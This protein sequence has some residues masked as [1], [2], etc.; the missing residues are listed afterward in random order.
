MPKR[1]LIIHNPVSGW[2]RQHRFARFVAALEAHGHGV[3]IFRTRAPG[4]AS[5]IAAELAGDIDVVVAAGGDGTINEVVN[6]LGAG[7]PPLA[8][9]P[10][11]TANVLAHEL[12]QGLSVK[13][14]LAAVEHGRALAFRPGRIGGKLFVLM[15]SS[16]VDARVVARVRGGPGKRL[17]GQLAYA[18]A[19][20][21]EIFRDAPMVEAEIDGAPARAALMIVTRGRCYGG[22]FPIAPAARLEDPALWLVTVSK[23]GVW[24]LIAAGLALLAGLAADLDAVA[25]RRVGTVRF[26]GDGTVPVQCDGDLMVSPVG[27]VGLADRAITLLAPPGQ[28]GVP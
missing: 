8:I 4:H 25:V 1:V 20:L 7:A 23:P 12:G 14:A 21:R 15:V 6:G 17:F 28:P 19:A 10:L 5:R 22:P 3:D 11:G 24:P 26:Q 13:A 18:A 27:P 16:G 9:M 2:F